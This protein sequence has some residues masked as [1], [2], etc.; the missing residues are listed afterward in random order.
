MDRIA[1]ALKVQL[2]DLKQQNNELQRQLGRDPQ[3]GESADDNEFGV[4]DFQELLANRATAMESAG[5]KGGGD[6]GGA[7][8]GGENAVFEEEFGSCLSGEWTCQGQDDSLTMKPDEK[9][10]GSLQMNPAAGLACKQD[11]ISNAL[12]RLQLPS[13]TAIEA[14]VG[15]AGDAENGRAGLVWYIDSSN[16][17][18]LTLGT[19]DSGSY[20][21]LARCSEGKLEE[22]KRVDLGSS[23]A[24]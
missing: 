6:K 24:Q 23:G 17:V 7:V 16:Y 10:G 19:A 14:T 4:I 8:L 15:I 20:A 21:L 18:A 13:C 2:S 11:S 3:M 22:V 5:G 12:L 1:T 9:A